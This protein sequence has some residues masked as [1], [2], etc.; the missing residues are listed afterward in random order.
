MPAVEDSKQMRAGQVVQIFDSRSQNFIQF[1]NK[2]RH[3]MVR[4]NA[5]HPY[6]IPAKT[7]VNPYRYSFLID[8]GDICQGES[9]FLLIVVPSVYDHQ[10]NRKVI[11]QTWGSV[12]KTGEWADNTTLPVMKLIFLFGLR[13]NSSLFSTV[14]ADN[15]NVFAM[16]KNESLV[17]GD[18]VLVDFVDSYKNLTI[19]SMSALY[20]A[21]QFCP[22]AKYL[23]KNDEDT[24]INLP[25]LIDVLKR[26][27]TD[28]VFGSKRKGSTVP[29]NGTL[30]WR[31]SVEEYPP[32]RYPPYIFGNYY[33]IPNNLIGKL[34][35]L[36]EYIPYLSM[37]DVFI[38]GIVRQ[39][40]GVSIKSLST[41]TCNPKYCRRFTQRAFIELANVQ[42]VTQIW[43]SFRSPTNLTCSGNSTS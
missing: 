29:R 30:K 40:A 38:T 27:S 17:Y 13:H 14:K 11:R 12:V 9:P 6:L 16:L 34:F 15:A 7:K 19:K 23:L 20:W 26:S 28:F 22:D 24:V 25:W 5:T 39:A 8:G 4:K 42:N 3:I 21:T 41:W 33:V 10:K 36:S 43:E 35:H 37:E 2:R 1:I 31:V 18:I 32:D